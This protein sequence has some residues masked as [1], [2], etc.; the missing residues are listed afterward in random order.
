MNI[1]SLH[2]KKFQCAVVYIQF[3]T[4]EKQLL[5]LLLHKYIAEKVLVTGVNPNNYIYNA[6]SGET[7]IAL[8][9]PENKI[10]QNVSLLYNFLNK[11]KLSS[12]Q[13]KLCKS[14]NYKKLSNDIKKFDV[15]ITGKCK[16]LNDVKISKLKDNI[17]SI[18][19]SD[20]ENIS[21]NGVTNCVYTIEDI[22]TSDVDDVMLYL[23]IVLTNTPC[24]ISKQGSSVKLEIFNFGMC[25]C[26]LKDLAN[27]KDTFQGH[28]KSFLVQSGNIGSP[29]SNDK[30]KVKFNEKVKNITACQNEL[31]FIYSDIRGFSYKFKN[32]ESMKKVNTNAVAK[33]KSFLSKVK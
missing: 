24:K 2:N 33:I 19:A 28:I 8:F 13:I 7:S 29:S 22:A 21:G 5:S 4:T 25:N 15:N 12:Q 17:K 18:E 14:G 30:G 26:V 31:A 1:K 6:I 10:T 23:S 27:V 32:E 11:S 16:R 20:R 3:N 9:V